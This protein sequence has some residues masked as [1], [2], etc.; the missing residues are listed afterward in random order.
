ML[1]NPSDELLVKRIEEKIAQI[2]AV[3]NDIPGVLIIHNVRTYSVEYISP[4]GEALLGYSLEEIKK[5]G[6]E[7]LSKFF[8]P[9]NINDYLPKIAG[10]IE[11]NIMEESTSFFE[12]V[13]T[14]KSQEWDW[15]ISSIKI[16]MRD[17]EQ[18]PILTLTLSVPVDP[19]QHITPKVSR[20]LDENIFIRK[21][22]TD[23]DKLSPRELEVLRFLALGKSAPETAEALF[24]TATTVETHR[25]NIKQKLKTNS[26]FE[27]CQYASAFDLIN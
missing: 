23:F 16:L 14:L 19:I 9:D 5:M 22:Q 1:D 12:Q 20:L 13:K 18:K 3:A 17:D 26:F 4:K 6:S 25:K 21:H 10:L 8:N 2:S 11:R 24:I 15:Y 7:Y 27:L